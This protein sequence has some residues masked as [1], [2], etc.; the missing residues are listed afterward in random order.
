M[1][2][3]GGQSGADLAGNEFAKDKKIPTRCYVFKGFKPVNPED[4]KVL[5][6]FKCVNIKVKHPK[7]YVACLKERTEYNVK[8]ADA[9]LIFASYNIQDTRG[10]KLTWQ[11]CVKHRKPYAIAYIGDWETAIA[12]ICGCIETHQPAVLNIA[13]ERKLDRKV[14]RSLLV[15]AWKEL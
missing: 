12:Q 2:I 6:R 7:N 11:L 13:G 9:T 10:S 5:K 1:I 14:V 4:E 3:S 8:Q 15:D